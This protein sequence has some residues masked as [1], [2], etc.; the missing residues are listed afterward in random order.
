MAEF[1]FFLLIP[2]AVLIV[3][4]IAGR[5]IERNHFRS[6]NEREARYR[7]VGITNLEPAVDHIPVDVCAYVDGQAVISAD[8][9]KQRLAAIRNVFG[10]EMRSMGTVLV[11]ARR[12]AVVR[13]LEQADR[14]GADQVWN[15]RIE[16]STI[17]GGEQQ[18]GHAMAEVHAY[19]TAVKWRHPA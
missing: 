6:L 8:V 14:L 10:G 17:G 4:W 9:F 2:V 19:G 15:M 7:H 5:I 11:R 18:E 12:E 1:L 13:M 16:T 3:G